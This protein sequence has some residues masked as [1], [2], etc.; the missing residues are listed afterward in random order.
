MQRAIKL[1]LNFMGDRLDWISFGNTRALSHRCSQ[2]PVLFDVFE[3]RDSGCMNFWQIFFLKFS[4]AVRLRPRCLA[5]M[6]LFERI[7]KL[8]ETRF[9]QLPAERETAPS[10]RPTLA[11]I[12]HQQ[13][14]LCLRPLRTPFAVRAAWFFQSA[15]LTDGQHLAL[16]CAPSQWGQD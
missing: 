12:F 14:C 16:N 6:A 10:S 7:K 15:T 11:L 5:R 1:L 9:K 3:L 2:A 13:S 8:S 4:V